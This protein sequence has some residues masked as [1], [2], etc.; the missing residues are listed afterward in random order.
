[1]PFPTLLAV[2]LSRQKLGRQEIMSKSGLKMHCNPPR[3]NGH[4]NFFLPN[5]IQSDSEFPFAKVARNEV[6][7]MFCHPSSLRNAPGYTA[8]GEWKRSVD[9]RRTWGL[10]SVLLFLLH[11]ARGTSSLQPL[12]ADVRTGPYEQPPEA[13]SA[14][15]TRP[16]VKAQRCFRWSPSMDILRATGLHHPQNSPKTQPLPQPG[17]PNPLPITRATSISSNS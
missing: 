12:D 2:R 3:Q 13:P 8:Q 17:N 10:E 16:A 14:L 7:A 11:D 1:M 5:Q 4:K 6:S 15:S 9:P